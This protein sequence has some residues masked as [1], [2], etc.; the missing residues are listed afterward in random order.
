MVGIFLFKIRK[1]VENIIYR[2]NKGVDYYSKDNKLYPRT[3][4][5]LHESGGDNRYLFTVFCR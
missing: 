4:Y 1:Q 2:K 3:I 5:N